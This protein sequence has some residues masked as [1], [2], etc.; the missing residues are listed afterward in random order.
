MMS[1]FVLFV[2]EIAV[3]Q[4]SLLARIHHTQHLNRTL[5]RLFERAPPDLIDWA[6]NISPM[7]QRTPVTQT[8]LMQSVQVAKPSTQT[9]QAIL[10]LRLQAR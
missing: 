7:A 1:V 3:S 2:V 5:S 9:V 10:A 6:S 8:I 4:L